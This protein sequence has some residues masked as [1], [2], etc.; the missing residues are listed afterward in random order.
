MTPPRETDDTAARTRW[1]SDA[2]AGRMPLPGMPDEEAS[3][4][5]LRAVRKLPP[6][7]QPS[8][9]AA[10]VALVRAFANDG[11]GEAAYHD[12]LLHLAG[13]L[14]LAE[15]G[16]ALRA[17]GEDPVRWQGLP[18]PT[19]RQVLLALLAVRADADAAFWSARFDEEPAAFAGPVFCALLALDPSRMRELW[20]KLPAEHT[21]ASIAAF[22]L[23]KALAAATDAD[24]QR[25]WCEAVAVLPQLPDEVLRS[26]LS[27]VLAG[28]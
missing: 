15:V 17:L 1:L 7:A 3:L 28:R 19:K 13:A 23:E 5:V 14:R 20:P 2:L 24:R 4:R 9:A 22:T 10:C 11:H 8:V 6:S 27:D 21:V 16:P 12:A 18:V 26:A 25:L